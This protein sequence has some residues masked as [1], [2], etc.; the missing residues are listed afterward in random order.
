MS[1]LRLN[2]VIE[3]HGSI[4]LLRPL[5]SAGRRWLEENTSEEAQWWGGALVVEPRYVEP[6]VTA[7]REAIQ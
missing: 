4:V 6:L 7:F 1:N 5:T 3:N 2:L